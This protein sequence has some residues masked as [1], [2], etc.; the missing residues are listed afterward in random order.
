MGKVLVDLSHPFGADIPLCPYF[1]K[2]VIDTWTG[3]LASDAC[4]EFLDDP[5]VLNVDDSFARKWIR[6][7]PAGQAWAE[8]MGFPDPVVF[9]P[10]RECRA[11]DPRPLFD[12]K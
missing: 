6:R 10:D 9:A 4:K 8:E 3:L 5:L 12:G 11:D 1:Q 2:P 7:D